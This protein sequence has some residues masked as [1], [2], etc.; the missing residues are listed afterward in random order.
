MRSATASLLRIPSSL[1]RLILRQELYECH[2]PRLSVTGRDPLAATSAPERPHLPSSQGHGIHLLADLDEGRSDEGL[3]PLAEWLLAR[4]VMW[5]PTR[6][7]TS[8]LWE[9]RIP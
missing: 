8:W 3:A 7:P 2:G 5:G 6:A 9:H 1:W 4:T